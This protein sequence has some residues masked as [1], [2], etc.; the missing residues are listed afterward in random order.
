MG[1][2]SY[3]HRCEEHEADGERQERPEVPTQ[4]P[5]R[6]EERRVVQERREEDEEDYLGGD[7]DCGQ[8]RYEADEKAAQDQ[9]DGIRHSQNPGELCEQRRGPEQKD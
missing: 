1:D 6:G 7:L 5:R 4:V 2:Q 8:A 9:E 3:R